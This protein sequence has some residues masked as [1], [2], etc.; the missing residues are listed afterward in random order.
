MKVPYFWGLERMM[1]DE[2][3]NSGAERSKIER[4][5]SL[6]A[7]MTSNA[8]ESHLPVFLPSLSFYGLLFFLYCVFPLY[9]A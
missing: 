5:I 4:G 9:E 3:K 2:T 7:F 1:S 8:P 6:T